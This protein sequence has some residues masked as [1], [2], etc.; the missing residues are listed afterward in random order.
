MGRPCP[1]VQTALPTMSESLRQQLGE[2]DE[3]L[4][5]QW[6]RVVA[7]FR[8]GGTADKVVANWGLLE[9]TFRKTWCS[10]RGRAFRAKVF[11]HD[12]QGLTEYI[13]SAAP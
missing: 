9:R 13:R 2:G 11:G 1:S 6:K 12:Q 4:Q 10:N 3:I 7:A 5:K 8:A